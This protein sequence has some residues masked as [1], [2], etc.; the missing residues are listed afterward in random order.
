MILGWTKR[1]SLCESCHAGCCRSFA[2]PVTG[3]DLL[4]IERRLRLPFA[5]FACRW[6][7]PSGV[8]ARNYAPHFYFDDEPHVPFVICLLHAPSAFLPGTTKCRFLVECPADA[9]HPLG[10]A[11]CGIYEHRPGACRAFPTRLN[12]T[13]DLAVIH[14]VPERGRAGDDPAYTLCPRPWTPDDLDPLETVQ[15]LVITKYEMA[16][17]HQLAR[18]WNRSPRPWQVFPDFL[19]LVY[20]A[21]V[22]QGGGATPR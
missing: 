22:Q 4:R 18:L 7:D 6:A 21:R 10:A 11:R 9:D 8:I 1:M 3:A 20:A 13:G 2:V 5:E 19:R 14:D 15:D 12:E 17:F 16:F